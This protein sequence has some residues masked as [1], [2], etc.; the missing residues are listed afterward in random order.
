[1][2]HVGID[3]CYLAAAGAEAVVEI[4]LAAL[5]VYAEVDEREFFSKFLEGFGVVACEDAVGEA[6]GAKE[7]L[8]AGVLFLC[9]T[10]GVAAE[11]DGGFAVCAQRESEV[12]NGEVGA[13][14]THDS[15]C[16]WLL[17]LLRLCAFTM[18]QLWGGSK[19]ISLAV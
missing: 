16:W 3:V 9:G 13:V 12:L 2:N 19:F 10:A 4:T 8:D 17:L 6:T 18:L 14:H 1:M 7:L 11:L 5:D 15:A